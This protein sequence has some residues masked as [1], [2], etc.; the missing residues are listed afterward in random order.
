MR[1]SERLRDVAERLR[2]HEIG[3]GTL[4]RIIAEVQARYWHSPSLSRNAGTSNWR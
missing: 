4:H 2:G 3:D 1:A